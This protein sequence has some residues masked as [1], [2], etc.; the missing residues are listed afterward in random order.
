[1]DPGDP[2]LET[3]EETVGE[4]AAAGTSSPGA[5]SAA[6][7]RLLVV[8][9]VVAGYTWRLLRELERCGVE[10]R[11]VYRDAPA[12]MAAQFAHESG[13]EG[14]VPALNA[15]RVSF[16][17]AIRFMRAGTADAILA[18]GGAGNLPLLL[19][20]TALGRRGTPVYL[21]T[22]ANV[23]VP[24]AGSPRDWGRHVLYRLLRPIVREAWTLGRSNED[25]LRAFGL[26]SHR[27]LPLYAS[28]FDALG[29]AT[30]PPSRPPG[31]GGRIRLLCV[32]RL[33]REKNLVALCE[34]LRGEGVEGRFEL[35]LVGEGPQ[36]AAV[37]RAARGA[38]APIRLLGSVPR[39]EMGGVF[40]RADALVLPSSWEPWG[41]AVVEALGLGLPVVATTRVGSAVSLAG[42]GG[43][44]L[45]P[46]TDPASLRR[47]LATLA[48]ELEALRAAAR[49]AAARVREE[50]GTEAVARRIASALPG[51]GR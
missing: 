3:E 11:A 34:A 30:P 24:P 21:F 36:R 17:E 51:D 13:P 6:R 38:G 50:F 14:D 4:A 42:G 35:T 49:T 44:V 33:S 32:A 26:R 27:R 2:E 15:D 19:A 46:G 40:A 10:V 41:I 47:A 12:A 7:P 16:L 5:R 23:P 28:D 45:A 37:E 39:R 9:R 31:P 48:D 29:A 20:A 18:L 22:D 8:G 43:I 1:M 25:A